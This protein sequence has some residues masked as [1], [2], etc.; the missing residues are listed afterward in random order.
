M[1]EGVGGD[2]EES[3]RVEGERMV[4]VEVGRGSG[5]VWKRSGLTRIVYNSFN[6]FLLTYDFFFDSPIYLYC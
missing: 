2:G 6:R 1:Y 5:G 4:G 3:V